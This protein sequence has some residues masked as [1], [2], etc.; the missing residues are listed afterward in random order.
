MLL[1]IFMMITGSRYAAAAP[2]PRIG[3]M[4]IQGNIET[5]TWN[6]EKFR[7]GLY[8]IRNGKRHNA[9]GSLGHDR[10]VPAHY[11][12]F[13]S[14]TTVHNEAGA[15]PEYSF[16]SGAKIRIVINHPENNGFLRK[17]MRITIYGYTVNGDEGGDWY[18][19]RKLSILHR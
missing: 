14:G 11:S 17:G 4:T 19:Y 7:K 10:T 2:R 6:P 18:R 9:S 1:G 13:L 15:D 12:I 8:T 3:P 16:K 5:I